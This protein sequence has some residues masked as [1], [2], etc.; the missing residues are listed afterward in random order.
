MPPK[1][2]NGKRADTQ[3][4]ERAP[5]LNLHPDVK[6]SIWIV[7]CIGLGIVFILAAAGQAGPVGARFFSFMQTFFGLGY[8]LLPLVSFLLAFSF[9]A[10]ERTK[11]LGITLI[12]GALFVLSGLG[13][14][15]IV[16]PGHGGLTGELIGAL[17]IPFGVPASF[18]ITVAVLAIS[19][20]LTVNR[21][22]KLSL[23][24]R[25]VGLL[26]PRAGQSVPVTLP[27]ASPEIETEEKKEDQETKGPLGAESKQAAIAEPKR[28]AS[29][30]EGRTARREPRP[31][32]NYV[33]PPLSLLASSVDKPT[34]GDL[35]ANA[36]IIR[37]TL[38][39]FGIPVE[40]GEINV[41]PTVTR[42]TLKPAEGV[43]LSRIT[44]LAPDLALALAAHPLRIEAP[45]PGKSVVGIEVPNKAA[46]VVRL[47]SLL[48]YPEFQKAEPLTFALGRNVQG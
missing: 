43:K 22:L 27:E 13:F 7:A 32:R 4:D 10:P 29:G 26:R 38:E 42:Y 14:I 2:T 1:R 46:A 44:A 35:Q 18:V 30:P 24:T 28:A 9:F 25:F 40:M 33:A 19:F 21:P 23:L 41:G 6:K 20:L 12:G 48:L 36:N 15:D 47:G 45:V 16:S 34:A 17:K 5:A 31:I 11:L 37:R 8:Y 3:R 39:S